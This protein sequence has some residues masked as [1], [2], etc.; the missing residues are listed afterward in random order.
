MPDD[1][2]DTDPSDFDITLQDFD[3]ASKKAKL[4]HLWGHLTTIIGKTDSYDFLG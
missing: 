4:A 1:L 3:F 2:L